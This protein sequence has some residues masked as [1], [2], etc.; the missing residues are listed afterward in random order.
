MFEGSRQIISVSPCE[1]M[2][3]LGGWGQETG[4]IRR[5]QGKEE[6]FINAEVMPK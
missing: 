6:D 5:H 4:E 3:S 2:E 1:Q